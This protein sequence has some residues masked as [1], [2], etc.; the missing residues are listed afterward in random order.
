MHD[1][2]PHVLG[3]KVVTFLYM[4]KCQG[5]PANYMC[6]FLQNDLFVFML[7][8]GSPPK[9]HAQLYVK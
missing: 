9:L 4:Q 7:C 8:Q 2:V 3:V 6:N 5:S 1:L